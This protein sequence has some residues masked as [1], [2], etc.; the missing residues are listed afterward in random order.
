MSMA[1]TARKST[2]TF[3][4][5]GWIKIEKNE[6]ASERNEKKTVDKGPIAYHLI[7]GTLKT[8]AYIQSH[9]IQFFLK[10]IESNILRYTHIY[11][12]LCYFSLAL[13]LLLQSAHTHTYSHF[14]MN[15]PVFFF[16]SFL[17]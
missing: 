17:S 13:L 6:R 8:N 7:R 10:C 9:S 12:T 3:S 11:N 1:V 15:V 14:V 2:L 16:F 5:S 4:L